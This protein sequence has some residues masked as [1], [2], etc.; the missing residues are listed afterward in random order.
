MLCC[1]IL[2]YAMCTGCYIFVD[3]CYI[4]GRIRC[5]FGKLAGSF[6]K[7]SGGLLLLFGVAIL[8]FVGDEIE[9]AVYRGG[10]A[11]FGAEKVLF[12]YF[13]TGQHAALP[14]ERGIEYAVFGGKR[15]D[16]FH[17]CRCL[18][19][20]VGGDVFVKEC[21]GE[22]VVAFAA[23]DAGKCAYQCGKDAIAFA[24]HDAAHQAVLHKIYV[25]GEIVKPP[26]FYSG[27]GVWLCRV[28]MH[29]RLHRFAQIREDISD[30]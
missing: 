3:K 9:A 19:V 30:Y 22:D 18:L 28:L 27:H 11:A 12:L 14:E 4:L 25:K 24:L 7:R 10:F 5:T 29:H 21:V 20:E 6:G 2:C 17:V 23:V 26:F 16:A 15:E 13:G 1:A 8:L